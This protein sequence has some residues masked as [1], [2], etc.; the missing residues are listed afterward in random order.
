[1]KSL[2]VE[3]IQVQNSM[4]C[5]HPTTVWWDQLDEIDP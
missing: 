1:L 4:I 2:Q 3:E 5:I